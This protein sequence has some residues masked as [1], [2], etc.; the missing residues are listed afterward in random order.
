MSNE[1]TTENAGFL[2]GRDYTAA[3]LYELLALIVGNGVYTN[4]LAPTATNENMTI[5]HGTGHA[6]INGVCY[7]NK[8]PFV[9]DI[10]TADGALNRYD[11]LMIRLDL[12]A[13]E[14]YALIV[15]GDY[16]TVPEPPA[17]VRNAEIHDL[18][19][20]DIYVP[21]GCTKITQA[22]IIDRRLDAAVCGVP[23]FPVQHMD[24]T[25]FYRQIGNDLANFRQRS[26]ADF[27]AWVEDQ[28]E[29]HL[30][31]M[32]ELVEVLRRTSDNSV[33]EIL[34]LLQ[35]LND[36]V[37]GETVGQLINAINEVDRKAGRIETVNG[38]LPENG[39]VQ[40]LA[41]DIPVESGGSKI[42]QVLTTLMQQVTALMQLVAAMEYRVATKDESGV[43]VPANDRIN[44]HYIPIS[45]SGWEAIGIVGVRLGSTGS[46][47]CVCY[48]YGIGV[49]PTDAKESVVMNI[50]NYGSSAAS[51][52]LHIDV[53]Y[54][55]VV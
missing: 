13:N 24:M 5:T 35:Q 38:V 29:S 55:K 42:D 46:S 3:F 28:E 8:T 25:S 34:T 47:T 54:R 53:L 23:V 43:S 14:V 17:C 39:N 10:A 6:W 26:E 31:T 49:N 20:C 33:A 12:S 1:R 19:I 40:L 7:K 21:A 37:D 16:A 51:L 52:A 2:D 30:A 48:S 18:K 32:A 41:S 45:E 27:A 50:R 11:S 9:L 15:Q 36:L 22:Q 44:N 4:E